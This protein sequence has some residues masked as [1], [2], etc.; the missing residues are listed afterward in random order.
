MKA[1]KL[2]YNWFF[3]TECGEEDCKAEV[4][5]EHY[6]EKKL[7]TEIKE[8][9]TDGGQLVWNYV[10]KFEDGSSIRIFN[11]NQVWYEEAK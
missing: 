11:P 5:K 6:S 4:G 9:I 2:T 3:S 10:I 1:I 7:V 8:N